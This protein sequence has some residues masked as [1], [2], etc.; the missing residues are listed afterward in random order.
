MDKNSIRKTGIHKIAL[1]GGVFMNVK[2]NLFI[3]N[4]KEVEDMFV[5]PSCGDESLAIG[6]AYQLYAGKCKEL[7]KKVNIPPLKDIYFGQEFSQEEIEERLNQEGITDGSDFK[8]EYYDEIEDVI[9]DLLA[10]NEI[11]AN[12][13]GRME[14]GARAL[15][16]RS[17]LANASDW[18]NVKKINMMIK[19]RD[20]WMP[21]APSIL[22][23]YENV[24]VENHKRIKAPYMIMAF[25]TK[26]EKV[27]HLIAAVHPYDLTARPQIVEEDWNPRYYKILTRFRENTGYGGLLNTSFNLHGDP[28]CCTPQDAIYTFKNSGI[29]YLAIGNFLVQKR[30]V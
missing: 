27:N 17:I 24:Y 3:S 29:R 4:L 15:G 6:A 2:A 21:F 9:A 13:Q 26:P 30:E 5:F 11:V 22:D 23:I 18:G 28:I 12:F 19:S 1:G 14:W 16:N 20:F 8:V 10:N 25:E 7:N